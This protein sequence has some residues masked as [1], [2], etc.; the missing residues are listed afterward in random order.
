MWCY[1][2]KLFLNRSIVFLISHTFV[3]F[4]LV[5]LFIE[6]YTISSDMLRKNYLTW[7][8]NKLVECLA[9]IHN[10]LVERL[11]W[12]HNRLVERLAWMHNRLVER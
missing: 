7:M 11:A 8:H 3:S 5:F 1:V 12:M 6:Q 10:R 2:G 4:C 9:W